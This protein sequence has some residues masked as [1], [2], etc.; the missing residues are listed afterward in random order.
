M[1]I[2]FNIQ[3]N[4]IFMIFYDLMEIYAAFYETITEMTI[5]AQSFIH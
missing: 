4:N 3:N 5:K 2:L 1:I